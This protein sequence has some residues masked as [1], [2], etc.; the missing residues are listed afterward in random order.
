M[1][2][3]TAH[4]RFFVTRRLRPRSYNVTEI[5]RHLPCTAAMRHQA[6]LVLSASALVILSTATANAQFAISFYGGL[7][8][9]SDADVR[10][11]QPG[12]TH[13]TLAGVS[14]TGES[15]ESPPYYGLRLSYWFGRAAR[16][17]LA[18]DFTHAKMY[19]E[20]DNSVTV[21]GHRGGTPVDDTE[22][23][24]D[25]FNTLSYSHGHN[26]L[27]LNGMYRWFPKGERD[28]TFLGRLQPYAGLG[29]G[30]AIPHV[31]TEIDAVVTDEYQ[32]SGPAL[33]GLGGLSFQ[34][35]RNFLLFGEYQLNY[36]RLEGDLT[37]GG[38]LE[39]KPC[40]HQLALG[41][42]LSL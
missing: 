25:T 20:L 16:W 28:G 5:V 30:I 3:C 26:L 9:T 7:A 2:A 38:S 17:G 37:D 35:T 10:L 32:L 22:R 6:T 31:E 40:T 36:A 13:L 18:V 41:L 8:H 42:T 1:R 33:E 39:V 23:L 4:C 19:G 21:S 29:L 11:V 15:L 24:G 12:G 14:W 34:I 27:T